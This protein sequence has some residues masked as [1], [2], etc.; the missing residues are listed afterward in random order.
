MPLQY[1]SW[2]KMRPILFCSLGPNE[3]IGTIFGWCCQGD[4][5]LKIFSKSN[6]FSKFFG[7][8]IFLRQS[9]LLSLKRRFRPKKIFV[10]K[11][12][13]RPKVF[14]KFFF[15]L[16]RCFRPRRVDWDQKNFPP[17]NLV[18]FSQK[19]WFL[20]NLVQGFLA[21]GWYGAKTE[22]AVSNTGLSHLGVF[23]NFWSSW[24]SS[25]DMRLQ[26]HLKNL[27]D[28]EK[29]STFGSPS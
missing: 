5:N 11:N 13:F 2:S 27:L 25:G 8:K 12:F 3:S 15:R 9:I 16:K 14:T 23:K 18:V 20:V 10:K 24:N 26:S 21:T 19:R 17:K 22:K 1:Q 29:F 4:P 28:L 7:E 6:F